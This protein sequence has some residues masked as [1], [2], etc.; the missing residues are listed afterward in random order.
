MRSF[1]LKESNQNI[2][3]E[4]AWYEA[5][6]T[7]KLLQATEAGQSPGNDDKV[8][9]YNLTVFQIFYWDGWDGLKVYILEKIAV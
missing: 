7:Q 9:T 2:G 6:A 3:G 5:N 4:M 1:Q 8:S